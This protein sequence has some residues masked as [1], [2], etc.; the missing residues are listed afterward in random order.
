[1]IIE[2]LL[3]VVITVLGALFNLLP[4][5]PAMPD[6]ITIY[7]NQFVEILGM[8]LSFLM[9]FL[10]PEVVMACLGVS[11]AIFLFDELYD[12][13]LWFIRKIP[14]LGIK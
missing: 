13:I 2:A 3:N 8:G 1:M 11:L 4:S 12:I 7:W 10:V 14:F 6:I 9:V 5:L